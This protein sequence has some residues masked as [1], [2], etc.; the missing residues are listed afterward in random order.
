MTLVGRVVWAVRLGCALA[1]CAAYLSVG[2][3]QHR[4]L[5]LSGCGLKADSSAG[6]ADA[7][8][9]ETD[10]A[11][12]DSVLPRER[13]N[14]PFLAL[15]RQRASSVPHPPL[16]AV[17]DAVPRGA[18]KIGAL[19]APPDALPLHLCLIAKSRQLLC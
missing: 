19:E 15:L 4:A 9:Y 7:L 16:F 8:F 10:H 13:D 12:D 6:H 2:G 14:D 17:R 3:G 1:L 5:P 18:D 11:D